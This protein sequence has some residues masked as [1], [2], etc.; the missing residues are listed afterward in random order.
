[1]VLNNANAQIY[2]HAIKKVAKHLHC[3]L[4]LFDHE[5]VIMISIFAMNKCKTKTAQNRFIC[6]N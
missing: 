1:M 3:E 2:L 4:E 5:R 6:K